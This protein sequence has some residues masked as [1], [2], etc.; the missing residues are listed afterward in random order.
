MIEH[1]I[2]EVAC[3]R[4]AFSLRNLINN[5]GPQ[6]GVFCELSTPFQITVDD[7]AFVPMRSA[8]KPATAAV[9]APLANLSQ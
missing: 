4:K 5:K 3:E 2:I 6:S 8:A 7:F 1:S 9:A